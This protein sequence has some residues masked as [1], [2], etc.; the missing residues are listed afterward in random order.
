MNKGKIQGT[1]VY[2]IDVNS[3]FP[4][5]YQPR[6]AFSDESLSSLADSI[7]RYGVLQPIVVVRKTKVDEKTGEQKE[8]FE[9]IAGERRLRASKIAGLKTI[10][11]V[12][13]DDEPSKEEQFELAIIENLHR[14]DL[15]PVDR[16]K[17]FRKLVNEFSLTHGE[18][19]EALESTP[20][21]QTG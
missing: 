8:Y 12:V 4:N 20:G 7:E 18:I 13:R 15:N 16:A 10:P 5:P 21:I 6:V 17:A 11:A 19:A 3:V 1:A 9:L 14:E 2:Q